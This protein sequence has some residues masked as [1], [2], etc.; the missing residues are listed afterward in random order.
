MR[1]NFGPRANIS[2]NKGLKTGGQYSKA[3]IICVIAYTR[4]DFDG[5][6]LNFG[7]FRKL[8]APK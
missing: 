5:T 1:C 3:L 7:P 2:N 6:L 8:G 4:P